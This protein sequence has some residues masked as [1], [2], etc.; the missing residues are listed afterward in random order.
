MANGTEVVQQV[1][2]DGPYWIQVVE[3]SLIGVQTIVLA[4]TGGIVWWYTNETK[5]LRKSSEKQVNQM[6]KQVE[7]TKLQT[8]LQLRPY[9]IL[10]KDNKDIWYFRNIG[11]KY[12][13][14][15]NIDNIYSGSDTKDRRTYY[16]VHSL[17]VDQIIDVPKLVENSS[18]DLPVYDIKS[19][20]YNLLPDKINTVHVIVSYFDIFNCKY[21]TMMEIG[22]KHCKVNS[23]QVS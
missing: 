14:N 20:F 16:N 8:D 17:G 2:R 3:I 12:A 5:K 9:V 10:E 6:Q 15:I 7:Q 21:F 23:V 1:V 19:Y 18:D 4:I 22:D 13:I 11:N